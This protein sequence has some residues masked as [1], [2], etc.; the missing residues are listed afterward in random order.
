MISVA[1]TNIGMKFQ[2]YLY[3][4]NETY[5]KA[6]TNQTKWATRLALQG[7]KWTGAAAKWREPIPTLT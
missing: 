2:D 1:K 6:K 4:D 7:E 5:P 3:A